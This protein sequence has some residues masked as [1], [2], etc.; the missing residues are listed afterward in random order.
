MCSS[1]RAIYCLRRSGSG[2]VRPILTLMLAAAFA[3]LAARSA[4]AIGHT[5]QDFRS[6]AQRYEGG[7]LDSREDLVHLVNLTLTYGDQRAAAR[8][9]RGEMEGGRIEDSRENWRRLADIWLML[10]E[11]EQARA[12]L[13]ETSRGPGPGEHDLMIGWTW[14]EQQDWKRAEDHLGRVLMEDRWGVHCWHRTQWAHALYN[15]SRRNAAL[16]QYEG[17]ARQKNCRKHALAWA[18]YA[19]KAGGSARP[20]AGS[21]GAVLHACQ[22]GAFVM[23]E[24]MMLAVKAQ[25]ALRLAESAEPGEGRSREQDETRFAGFWL[26]VMARLRAGALERA[27]GDV[28]RAAE[29]RQQAAAGEEGDPSEFVSLLTACENLHEQRVTVLERAQSSAQEAAQIIQKGAGP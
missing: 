23:L 1:T 6:F 11:W 14:F 26:A 21:A 16:K 12:A 7:R 8:I 19:R 15:L 27:R 3:G 4:V 17:A 13:R 2:F 20:P 28:A 9:L 29:T 24:D 22:K 18:A 10:R 25:V 5:E